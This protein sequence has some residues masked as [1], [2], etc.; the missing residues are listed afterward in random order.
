MQVPRQTAQLS[1]T[2]LGKGAA[3]ARHLKSHPRLSQS[4]VKRF[5]D[6]LINVFNTERILQDQN[7]AYKPLPVIK[8]FLVYPNTIQDPPSIERGLDLQTAPEKPV[9]GHLKQSPKKNLTN[10]ALAPIPPLNKTLKPNLP[11]LLRKN[12][13]RD[14]LKSTHRGHH[15]T[16]PDPRRLKQN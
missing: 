1:L 11:G 8:S 2:G 10:A 3:Q 5:L 9:L 16:S 15:H 14:P 7:P 4:T 6:P 12:L 13:I